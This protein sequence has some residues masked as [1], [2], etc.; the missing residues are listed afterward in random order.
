M[1]GLTNALSASHVR[2]FRTIGLLTFAVM[3][4]HNFSKITAP[5]FKTW[6]YSFHAISRLH[7]NLKGIIHMSVL[8]TSIRFPKRVSKCNGFQ[9]IKVVIYHLYA[10]P[11][12]LLFRLVL[13]EFYNLYTLLDCFYILYRCV[14]YILPI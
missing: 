14:T 10:F 4:S 7:P 2:E 1:F 3:L 8:L 13:V 9:K 5:V 6:K 12:W 11:R